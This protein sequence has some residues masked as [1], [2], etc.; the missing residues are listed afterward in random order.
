MRIPLFSNGNMYV[1][2]ILGNCIGA[3]TSNLFDSEINVPSDVMPFKCK[4][5]ADEKKKLDQKI[6]TK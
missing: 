1:V 4:C 3:L 6:N 5:S 2:Y